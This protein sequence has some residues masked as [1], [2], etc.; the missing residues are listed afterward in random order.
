MRTGSPIST[1]KIVS[2]GKINFN[3]A[4]RPVYNQSS[5]SL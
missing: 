1:I 4:H 2:T 3:L 5:T